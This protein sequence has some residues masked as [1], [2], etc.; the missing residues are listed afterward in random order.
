MVVTANPGSA[1]APRLLLR[2]EGLAVLILSLALYRETHTGWLWFALFFFSPDVSMLG[3]LRGPGIGALLYNAAH[4][5]LA[6]LAL[7][8]AAWLAHAPALWPAVF[9]WTAH[10]GLDRLLGFGLKYPTAFGHTHLGRTGR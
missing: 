7:A 3:Y 8:A 5:Y 9:L 6:P 2:L 4:W 1:A 10:I